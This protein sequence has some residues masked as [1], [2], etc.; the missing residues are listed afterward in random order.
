MGVSPMSRR[1]ILVLPYP[2]ALSFNWQD[3]HATRIPAPQPSKSATP[4]A[5]GPTAPFVRS[6]GD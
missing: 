3:V 5:P 1:T 6:T 2:V 4:G